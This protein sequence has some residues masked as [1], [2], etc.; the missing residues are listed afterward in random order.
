MG[1]AEAAWQVEVHRRRQLQSFL[2]SL[3]LMGSSVGIR[4]AEFWARVRSLEALEPDLGGTRV[5]GFAYRRVGLISTRWGDEMLYA[6]TLE[7]C[8]HWDENLLV[9]FIARPGYAGA[10]RPGAVRGV[11]HIVGCCRDSG[12]EAEIEI[13]QRCLR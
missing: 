8:P 1:R 10:A 4:E 9:F 11:I 6:L 3:G 12:R 7:P 13:I 5:L 2:E